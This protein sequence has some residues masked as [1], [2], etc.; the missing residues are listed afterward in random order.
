MGGHEPGRICG[1]GTL[2]GLVG[3]E[4]D[5]AE[6]R[7]MLERARLVM[8]TGLPGV[9]KTAVG[10]A[11]AAA[12]RFPDGAFLVPLD[13]VRDGQ[14]LPSVIA[15]ALGLP[16]Q[17][18]R[19][20]AEAL[21]AELQDRRLL[22]VLDTCEHLAAACTELATALLLSPASGVRIL[23]T[24][25]EVL[26]VPGGLLVPLDPLPL[27]DAVALFGVRAAERS[28]G[29][30]VTEANEDLVAEI[31]GRLDRLPLAIELAARQLAYGSLDR[32]RSWLA[33]GYSFLRQPGD[34]AGR[35]QSWQSE[36]DWSRRLCSPDE[37]LAWARLSLA[38][39]PVGLSAALAACAGA[40]LSGA[41]TEAAVAALVTKSVLV[42]D[43]DPG[44][45]ARF[46]LP[47]TLRAY[48]AEMLRELR[49]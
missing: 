31:C 11:A 7:V 39:G 1:P 42:M 48:G 10:L 46:R 35:Q 21:A 12:A 13:S 32:L 47:E 36:L 40:G 16:D 43:F 38:D 41:R 15:A 5:V 22:L 49:G 29:F 33:A 4:S 2:G 26:R 28:P 45:Q 8:I 19:G 44:G 17:L 20:R 27:P 18:I 24:S 25:R 14:Q 23:V 34:A 37:Q 6:V 3:R 9:G 30:A